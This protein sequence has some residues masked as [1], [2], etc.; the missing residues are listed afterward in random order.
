MIKEL[1]G[2]GLVI[3]SLAGCAPPE[4]GAVTTP[5]GIIYFNEPSEATKLHEACHKERADREGASYWINMVTD[6]T[7][8]CT[9]EKRCGVDPEKYPKTYP[10][11]V[12]K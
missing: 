11:C 3:E 8:S 1:I 2:A 9:E 5:A 7:F 12:K 10:Q 4:M 6:P